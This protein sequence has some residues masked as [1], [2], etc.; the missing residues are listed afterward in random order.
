MLNAK[1]NQ[2]PP[3]PFNAGCQ[4]DKQFSSAYDA[5]FMSFLALYEQSPGWHHSWE[6]HSPEIAGHFAGSFEELSRHSDNSSKT[7][8][9]KAFSKHRDNFRIR[10]CQIQAEKFPEGGKSVSAKTILE[11]IFGGDQG[12]YL[13]QSLLCSKCQTSTEEKIS[14]PDLCAKAIPGAT[15]VR[16]LEQHFSRFV[17]DA[18]KNPHQQECPS[19]KGENEV[20]EVKI[21]GVPWFWLNRGKS[22]STIPCLDLTFRSGSQDLKYS[23]GSVIY[24]TGKNKYSARLRDRL[25]KWW[26]YDSLARSGSPVPD[27]VQHPQELCQAGKEGEAVALI[28]RLDA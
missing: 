17:E 20:Q 11:V 6:Q 12:P 15:F 2:Q 22:T 23:L 9:K 10:L 13:E 27:D 4:A 24:L 21:P 25:G 18:Q 3:F 16:L 28:Y 19:C 5:V 8:L 26:W 7:D 1:G 14:F